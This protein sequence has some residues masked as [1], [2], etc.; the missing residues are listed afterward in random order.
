MCLRLGRTDACQALRS[1][2]GKLTRKR[3]HR[4]HALRGGCLRGVFGQQSTQHGCGHRCPFAC[5]HTSHLLD[6]AV[7]QHT[8][9]IF[10]NTQRSAG[11]FQALVFEEAQQYRRALC[12]LECG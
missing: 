1:M 9:C 12:I 4:F 2:R 3:Q 10:G 11:F 5:Q 6:G 8:R 7:D